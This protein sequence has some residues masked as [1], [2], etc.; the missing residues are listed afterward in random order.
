MSEWYKPEFSKGIILNDKKL[1]IKWPITMSIISE[2]DL[3]LPN[4]EQVSKELES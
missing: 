2:K 1:G 3:S 4:L